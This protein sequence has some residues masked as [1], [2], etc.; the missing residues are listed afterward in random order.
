MRQKIKAMSST[1][2]NAH[3]AHHEGE[4]EHHYQPQVLTMPHAQATADILRASSTMGRTY[5][6]ALALTGG[7]FIAGIIAFIVRAQ[8]G[9]DTFT[10][11]AYLMGTFAF[12]F[13]TAMS[14]PIFSVSQRMVRSHWRRPMG[15]SAEILSVAGIVG[16]LMFIP[17]V[18]LLPNAE[19]RK[20]IWSTFPGAPH[21]YELVGLIGIA[22]LGMT[23]LYVSSLP[24]LAAIRDHGT[25]WRKSLARKLAPNF[26]GTPRDWKGVKALLMVLG[27]MYFLFLIGVH[28]MI[29]SDFALSLVPGWKDAI[30]PAWHAISGLQSAVACTILVTFLLYK[31]GG[32]KDYISVD[33]FWGASKIM[34]ALSLLW[35]YFWLSGFM[36]FWYGRQP[37]ELAII[38]LFFAESYRFPWAMAASLNFGVPFLLLIWNAAR[39][40]MIVPTIV[41]CSILLGTFF[42]RIRIY[43]ASFSVADVRADALHT[44]HA[45]PLLE[46]PPPHLPGTADVFMILGGLGGAIFLIMLA[47]KFFP[48]ISIWEVT[49]GMLYRKKRRFLKREIMVMGKPD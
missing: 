33:Q 40:S 14:A 22:I 31:F 18:L 47:M 20:S 28:T 39:K 27:A 36:I 13:T 23:I 9:F 46:N 35:M 5:K 38:K 21:V 1:V 6:L 41:A 45:E 29:A 37:V 12:I 49:E 11:W 34:L 26:R 48:P 4:G 43:V 10:P 42:D 30:F 44:L 25:G 2:H 15:R 19:N 16:S 24:D 3:T 17:L 32:Y 7:L 8:D